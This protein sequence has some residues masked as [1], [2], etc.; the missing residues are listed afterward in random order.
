[1]RP[2]GLIRMMLGPIDGLKGFGIQSFTLFSFN[3]LFFY[4]SHAFLFFSDRKLPSDYLRHVGVGVGGLMELELS[5]WL[6]VSPTSAKSY[7]L[8]PSP[9]VWCVGVCGC[10]CVLWA[11][12]NAQHEICE[13]SV[14][15]SKVLL[16]AK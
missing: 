12:K 16:G 11:E 13:L 4:P 7:T 3:H 9:R 8:S 2:Q 15:F 14:Q 6:S 1:M 5:K 10:V